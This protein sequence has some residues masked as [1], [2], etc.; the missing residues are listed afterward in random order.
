VALP[1]AVVGGALVVIGSTMRLDTPALSGTIVQPML[2]L[3]L[4]SMFLPLAFKRPGRLEH[5]LPGRAAA[6]V[7]VISYAVL[8]ANEP[9]RAV[10]LRLRFQRSSFDLIWVWLLYLP[11]TFA[12]A[13]P[14]AR[15]LG[16]VERSAAPEAQRGS[17]RAPDHQSGD[18]DDG[19]VAGQ[20]GPGR[21][22]GIAVRRG[23]EHGV[24]DDRDGKHDHH[25]AA[26]EPE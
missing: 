15:F 3:G 25:P 24:D 22:E 18:D 9:L 10:T 8:I 12:I 19:H 14:V 1:L 23:Q 20:V 26:T 6:W 2:A 16:L 4:S 21:V 5:G 13:W 7:G 17:V 11:L